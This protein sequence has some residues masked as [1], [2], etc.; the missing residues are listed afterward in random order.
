MPLPDVLV[1][2]GATDHPQYA[3]DG[4]LLTAALTAAGFKTTQSADPH[5]LK[6]LLAGP[7]KVVVLYTFG[8]YL[9]DDDIDALIEFVRDGNGLVGIHTAIATNPTSEPLGKLLGARII[10]GV[11]APHT[12]YVT[13]VEHPIARGTK[14]FEID[15]ELY[16]TQKKSDYRPF[17]ATRHEDKELPMGWSRNEGKGKVV[18][19]GNGHTPGGLTHPKFKELLVRSVKFVAG[20]R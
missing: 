8:D 16:V 13:D 2:A 18:Y 3:R 15:D 20:E 1:L 14:G 11:I 5:E 19:L 7:Y 6:Q 12:I 17:L 9:H 4:A 10:K